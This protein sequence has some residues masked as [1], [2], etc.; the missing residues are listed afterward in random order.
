MNDIKSVLERLQKE[1]GLA[2]FGITDSKT[3]KFIDKILNANHVFVA[4]KG[5][6]DLIAQCFAMR[7]MQL[8][9]STYHIGDCTTPSITKGDLLIA[10]SGSGKTQTIKIIME[11]A[12]KAGGRVVLLTCKKSKKELAMLKGID[13]IIEIN[14]K[15]KQDVNS[16]ISIAPLGTLFEEASFLYL[17]A[18]V[19]LIMEKQHIQECMLGKRH[20]NLE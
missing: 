7:L 14:A 6:S 17:D 4:G 11:E 16:K 2:F 5:R 3:N 18:V 12:K 8:G 20:S 10:I 19:V 13:Q 9:I 1:V 15:T